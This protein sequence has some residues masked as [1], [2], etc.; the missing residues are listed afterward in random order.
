MLKPYI[1]CIK[2]DIVWGYYVKELLF[3]T[4]I[5]FNIFLIC[6]Y[7][8]HLQFSCNFAFLSLPS[9]FIKAHALPR[10]SFLCLY[11]IWYPIL[12]EFS[13]LVLEAVMANEDATKHDNI[14][15]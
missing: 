2:Q 3:L 11:Q 13:I 12:Y 6:T 8:S 7:L 1:T 4:Y 5:Q 9:L 15:W 14:M 10:Y